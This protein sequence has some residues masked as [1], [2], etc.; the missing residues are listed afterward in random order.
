[1]TTT[2]R[3]GH[4][5]IPCLNVVIYL[6]KTIVELKTAVWKNCLSCLVES[7]KNEIIAIRTYLTLWSSGDT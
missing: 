1:M 7:N 4:D 2:S 3:Q 6:R 5:W